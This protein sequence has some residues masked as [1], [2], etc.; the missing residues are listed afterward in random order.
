MRLANFLNTGA[1]EM[2][3]LMLVIF[4]EGLAEAAARQM[5]SAREDTYTVI[6]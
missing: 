3:R 1:R 6:S 2:L 4:V 5:I